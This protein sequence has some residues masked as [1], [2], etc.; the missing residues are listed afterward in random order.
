MIITG[1]DGKNNELNLI[2]MPINIIGKNKFMLNIGYYDP[3][4]NVKFFRLRFELSAGS[5]IKVIEFPIMPKKVI[6][7][8]AKEIPIEVLR[9][10]QPNE[11]GVITISQ[12]EAD[13]LLEP[14]KDKIKVLS[15]QKNQ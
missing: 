15:D 1:V 2:T 9:Q 8:D 5:T 14:L 10:F 4:N 3:L 6:A 12:D 11:K 13:E 7:F